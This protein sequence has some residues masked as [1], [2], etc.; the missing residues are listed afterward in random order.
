[1][2]I[3]QPK[4]MRRHMVLCDVHSPHNINLSPVLSF[5]QDYKPT[6][7]VIN[8]DYL[9]CE[10][11]SHWN[12]KEFKQI[13]L[14]KLS[15]MLRKE[16][17]AGKKLLQ[18]ITAALPA[19]CD[20]YYVPGNHEEWLYW[21]LLTYPQLA[22]GINLGVDKMTFKSDLAK[23]R[24]QVLANVLKEFLET[25]KLGFKVL[26]YGKELTLGKISY[27]HG[28]QVSSLT[29]A[30]RKYPARNLVMGHHH[31]M[32]V[33]T[34]HNSGNS[35]RAN[36][37]VMVPCLCHLC[38]G[39]LDDDSTRWLNGF[40]IADVLPSGM[41]DGKVVKVIDGMVLYGGSIYK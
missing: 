17:N 26:P 38:P 37:Y 28:H 9:N 25:D 15:G 36:Q 4:G 30:K 11:A 1:M 20:K 7:F 32:Q 31:T 12:E 24:K 5:A 34:I 29:A 22:G 40:W 39:Y 10:W 3:P 18:E 14:E 23:I 13:G 27:L 16:I 35:R 19:D 21:A 6:D 33:E 41:F 8:G 2:K